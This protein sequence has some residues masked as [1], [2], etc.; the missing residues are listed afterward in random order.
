MVT[1]VRSPFVEDE[2]LGEQTELYFL[3][4]CVLFENSHTS[5]I[6]VALLELVITVLTI[7]TKKCDTLSSGIVRMCI[8]WKAWQAKVRMRQS[9]F[10]GSNQRTKL[11]IFAAALIFSS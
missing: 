6:T 4:L 5:Y 2:L 7:N 1:Q 3:R 11:R 10:E 8:V 9:A